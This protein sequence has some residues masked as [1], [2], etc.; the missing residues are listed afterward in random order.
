MNLIKIRTSLLTIAGVAAALAAAWYSVFG[1]KPYTVT[2]TQ[3]AERYSYSMIQPMTMQL[4]STDNTHFSFSYRS[5]D[6]A[7]VNGQLRYP[8]PLSDSSK[9]LPVL[10]GAHAMGRSQVRWWQDSYNGRPTLES[11]DQ[12]TAMALANGYA[13]VT[14]DAR[15]HGERKDPSNGIAEI[16]RNLHWWGKREPYEAMLI[17]TVRDHRVLLDLLTELPQFDPNN[18]NIAGYSMGAHISL[19]LAGSD[20]RINRVLAIVPPHINNTT[21]IVAP[22]NMLAGLADNPIWLLSANQDEYASKKQNSHLFAAF[23]SP[24]KKHITFDGGHL[25][26]ASY[27]QTL[28]DWFR[29]DDSATQR[30]TD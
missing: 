24:D 21:A 1:L 7:V 25:L 11:T 20:A 15:N 18:I 12:I 3:I 8:L 10:I 13:V 4:E 29:H 22:K 17:D 28:D 23:P 2:P 19:L 30:I 16:I 27:V 9:P 14:I 5:F 6:G 26:P